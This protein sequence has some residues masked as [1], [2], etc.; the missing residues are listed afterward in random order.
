MLKIHLQMS[1]KQSVFAMKDLKK[2]IFFVKKFNA[3]RT[4]FLIKILNVF[5]NKDSEKLMMFASKYFVLKDQLGAMRVKYV[6][7]TKWIKLWKK[8][9]C[10]AF[11]VL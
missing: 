6:F 10:N 8:I 11:N 1:K 4:K 2:W 7:V 3:G 5:A 9:R